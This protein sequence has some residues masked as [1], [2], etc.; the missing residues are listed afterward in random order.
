[1]DNILI[2]IQ[3]EEN[4]LEGEVLLEQ[5]E[6]LNLV[7]QARSAGR[8]CGSTYYP[9]VDSLKW[10]STVES[11]SRIHSDDMYRNNFFSH[12][13][14]DGSSVGDRLERVSYNWS[15]YG[16]NIAKGYTSEQ[17]VI[18]A[19]LESPGHC[20]NIMRSYFTEMGLSRVGV[21]WTQD[22]ASPQ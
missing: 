2:P 14:S 13:G 17:S 12:T 1:M 11:A 9:P 5:D 21:Y 3:V 8:T 19:W 7:N 6:L 20:A 4:L 16:E 22:F 15:S 10:S 18:D